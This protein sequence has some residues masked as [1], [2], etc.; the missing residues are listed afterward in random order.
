VVL[1]NRNACGRSKKTHFNIYNYIV[2]F[3]VFQ[4]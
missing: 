1:I 4:K 3:C 2:N